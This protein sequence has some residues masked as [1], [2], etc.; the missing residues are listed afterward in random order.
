MPSKLTFFQ[1]GIEEN[2]PR[3]F[4]DLTINAL[5]GE[6]Q[7]GSIETDTLTFVGASA[8]KIY[9][10][11]QGGLNGSTKGIFQGIPYNI[12]GE[13]DLG[14][15]TVFDGM[16]ETFNG[17]QIVQPQFS[18][19]LLP[20]EVK[21][22]IK[23]FDN[24][25]DLLSKAEGISMAFLAE[26]GFLTAEDLKDLPFVVEKKLGNL[27]LAILIVSI[28]SVILSIIQ[29]FK[30]T[31]EAINNTV[32]H[33]AGG[34]I[35]PVAGAIFIVLQLI[36]TGVVLLLQLKALFAMVGQLIEVIW[37]PVYTHKLF[38][39]KTIMT[40]I[41]SYG[42]LEFETDIPNLERY[43]YLPSKPKGRDLGNSFQNQQSSSSSISSKKAKG[44]FSIIPKLP[45]YGMANIHPLVTSGIPKDSDFGY[46]AS[47]FLT[48]MKRIFKVDFAILDGKL[49]MRNVKSDWWNKQ[50]DF[51][52]PDVIDEEIEYNTGELQGTRVYSH[53]TDSAD[54]FTIDNYTGTSYEVKTFHKNPDDEKLIGIKGLKEVQTNM[55]LPSRKNTFT[56]TELT[57]I[58]LLET[59]SVFSKQIGNNSVVNAQ[60]SERIGVMKVSTAY[61]T[62]AKIVYLKDGLIPADHR[63]FIGWKGLYEAWHTADSF[64]EDNFYGQKVLI[65]NKE[66]PFSLENLVQMKGFSQSIDF[67]SSIIKF[68]KLEAD[69]YQDSASVSYYKRQPYDKN[70]IETKIEA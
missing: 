11:V 64:V 52:L 35:G 21:A 68:T 59:A 10:Y 60:I 61:H 62:V 55:A 63:D 7:Q 28:T 53:S 44:S 31:A 5:F 39:Y 3:E 66:I 69:I 9:D 38:T 8:Q 18:G 50:S 51:V 48:L 49:Q 24:Y 32:A 19:Q 36:V 70:L 43:H 67:D 42:G 6:S 47:D 34:I 65:N 23:A 45:I 22:R 26:K 29:L 4:P 13:S 46:L 30:D 25:D 41:A 57:L 58:Q 1:N 33:I 15:L 2:P 17:L 27:E 37:S 56:N 12:Q 40:A 54:E 14:D 16:I 20:V